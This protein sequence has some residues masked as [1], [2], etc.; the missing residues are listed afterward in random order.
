MPNLK[1]THK[2]LHNLIA[3]SKTYDRVLSLESAWLAT[4]AAAAV[5][6]AAATA[7]S[8]AVVLRFCE[9]MPKSPMRTMPSAVSKMFSGFKSRWMIPRLCKYLIQSIEK[10]RHPQHKKLLQL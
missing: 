9:L 8:A 3:Q 10:C 6:V 7:K 1:F 4:S 5:A 2:A